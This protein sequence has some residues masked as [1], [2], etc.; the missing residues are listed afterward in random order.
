MFETFFSV[1]NIWGITRKHNFG[2]RLCEW[3][4]IAP[5]YEHEE[6][7]VCTCTQCGPVSQ[8][9]RLWNKMLWQLFVHFRLP[10]RTKITNFW[11]Q[12]ITL[13]LS[14]GKYYIYY[15]SRL[16]KWKLLSLCLIRRSKAVLSSSFLWYSYCPVSLFCSTLVPSSSTNPCS[17]W[18]SN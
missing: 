4:V 14:N 15:I 9:D 2:R 1:V 16:I 6:Q 10:W 17:A 12:V 13:S 3:R 11:R 5:I 7:E 8:I 18:H